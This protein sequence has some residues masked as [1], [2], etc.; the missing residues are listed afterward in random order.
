[1]IRDGD[2][3]EADYNWLRYFYMQ[4]TVNNKLII[5]KLAISR[6]FKNINPFS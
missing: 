4:F 1:M 3:L 6:V 2:I 5:N